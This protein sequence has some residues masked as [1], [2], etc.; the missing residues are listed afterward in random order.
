MKWNFIGYFEGLTDKPSARKVAILSL[1][2]ASAACAPQNHEF[3]TASGA[4]D[5]GINQG[6][7]GGTVSN[8]TEEYSKT[9]VGLWNTAV[10]GLCTASILSK[11]ILVTAAHCVEGDASDL[12][13]VFNTDLRGD[14]LIMRR[15]QRA[16]TSDEWAVNQENN[17]DQGDIAIVQIAG[18][19]PEGFHPAK[20]LGDLRLLKEGDDVL[21]A[22]YGTSDGFAHTG[23]KVLRSVTTQIKSTSFAKTETL[24]DQ[25]NGKGACHGD[26]G[27][28]AYALIGGE[29][30]LFGVTSRGVGE[31]GARCGTYVAYTDILPYKEWIAKTVAKFA[32]RSARG[33]FPV[34][35]TP[36]SEKSL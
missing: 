23:S 30:R 18:G 25:T 14:D 33:G 27:G 20:M 28:P 19:I 2:L 5:Q 36:S 17:V 26:S 1:A 7:I 15:V 13:A 31:Q 3:S 21:L 8:G 29:L 12:V 24:I 4:N 35:S 32:A 34:A 10:G 22:G 16:A 9:V 6:I 11:T